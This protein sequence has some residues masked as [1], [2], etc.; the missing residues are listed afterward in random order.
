MLEIQ[1]DLG[2]QHQEE[3]L[4]KLVYLLGIQLEQGIPSVVVGKQKVEVQI[5]LEQGMSGS[6][7]PIRAYQDKLRELRM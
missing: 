2:N 7:S 5:R 1:L 4:D 6:H 3:L